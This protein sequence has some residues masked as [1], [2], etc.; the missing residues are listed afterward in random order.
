MLDFIATSIVS[1]AT[2]ATYLAGEVV[3]PF[4]SWVLAVM[5]LAL[6]TMVSLSGVRESARIALFV[7]SLHVSQ[8]AFHLAC[9]AKHL[10]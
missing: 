5:V 8:L 6:F 7:L 2:A 3:L 4:P 9:G 10:F 1:S